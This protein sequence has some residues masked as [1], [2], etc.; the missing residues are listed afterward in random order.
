MFK[1]LKWDTVGLKV[2]GEN[3][4]HL[5]FA[6]DIVLISS[7]AVELQEMISQLNLESKRLGMKMNMKKTNVMFNRFSREMEVQV[8]GMKIGKVDEYV[9]LGQLVTTQ[10]DKTDEIKR[11]IVAGWMAFNKNRDI[12][13]SSV[14]MCL[15][16][17]VYN[18]CVMTA[19]TYGS[20]TWAITKRMQER[21][22]VTQRSMERAMVGTSRRDR[23]TNVWLRQQTGVEDIVCRMKKLKWQWAGHIAR[24]TDNRWTKI[25]TEWIP[26]EGKR[27]KGRPA[28]RWID[29]IRKFQGVTWMRQANN[30][31]E[32]CRLGEAFIQQWI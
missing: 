31:K 16:R 13:K 2:N 21:L 5:R 11:R 28:T 9:Y 1:R 20:Q 7:N 29:D 19:M 24:S 27:K 30:R 10:N 3:I 17:K 14:P 23:K 32:W 15:K 6:D 26:L 25:V 18:Q 12:L 4:N 8:D 22:R